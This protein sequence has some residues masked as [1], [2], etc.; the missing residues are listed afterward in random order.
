MWDHGKP[1]DVFVRTISAIESETYL[2][3]H[4]Q[5]VGLPIP[6]DATASLWSGLVLVGLRSD[7]TVSGKTF[8]KGATVAIP[9]AQLL[10]GREKHDGEPWGVPK[11]DDATVIFEPSEKRTLAG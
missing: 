1:H 8:K 9:L 7:W 3:D 6:R 11:V 10:A 4:D 2:Y 5:L